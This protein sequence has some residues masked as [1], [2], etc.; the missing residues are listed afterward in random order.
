MPLT[1]FIR[2]ARSCCSRS[3]ADGGVR[4]L[5]LVVDRLADVVEEAAASWPHLTSAPSSAA[6]IAGEVAD[7]DEWLSTFWP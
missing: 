1:T 6:I 5:D 3:R 2:H 7:L 4:A